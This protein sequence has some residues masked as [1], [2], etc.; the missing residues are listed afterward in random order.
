MTGQELN[1]LNQSAPDLVVEAGGPSGVPPPAAPGSPAQPKPTYPWVIA[2]VFAFFPGLPIA[3]FLI[4]YLTSQ[5][6]WSENHLLEILSLLLFVATYLF[7]RWVDRMKKAH[8]AAGA[9]RLRDLEAELVLTMVAF[10][11]ALAG[12]FALVAA[13]ELWAGVVLFG[14]LVVW[15]LL[16]SVPSLRRTESRSSIQA[17]CT[18]EAAF[19][20]VTDPG[21]WR[22]WTPELELAEPSEVPVGLGTVVRELARVDG[23]LLEGE[24]RIVVFD[25]PRR[26]GT[27]VVGANSSDMY[28]IAANEAGTLI[29]YTFRVELPLVISVYGGVFIR[30]YE[31]KKR[32]ERRGTAMKRIKQLL[33]EGSARPV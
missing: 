14:L 33:E 9:T 12:D 6:P 17:A 24:D 26:C 22:L 2:I 30:R 31:T 13:F 4:R 8:V 23:R 5:G 7:V 3:A 15:I 20:L 25:P 27:E 19:A 16:C 10:A 29:T 32:L 21:R 11:L 18:P 28:E 1:E